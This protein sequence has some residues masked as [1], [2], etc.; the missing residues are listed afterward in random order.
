MFEFLERFRLSRHQWN[1]HRAQPT[2]VRALAA[3]T[4]AR[5]V[6]VVEESET[7]LVSPLLR[8]SC[9]AWSAR[10]DEKRYDPNYYTSERQ[11]P[12]LKTEID[13][14]ACSAFSILDDE[15]GRLSIDPR[16]IELRLGELPKVNDEPEVNDDDPR[17]QAFMNA[18]GLRTTR[19]MGIAGEHHFYEWT[20]RPGDRIAL[21]GRASV[22]TEV[23]ASGYRDAATTRW[24]LGGTAEA[25][26]LLYP[27]AR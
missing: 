24:V 3:D 6:G 9:V 18:H 27:R 19:H 25:P 2:L 22:S 14:K 26:V 17:F 8:R 15:G 16:A 21:Y 20:L 13:Q 4:F 10:V 11:I 1:G 12:W 5:V 7:P 23:A